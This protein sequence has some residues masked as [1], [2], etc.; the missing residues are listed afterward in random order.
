MSLLCF[1]FS[2][3]DIEDRNLLVGYINMYTENYNIAQEL[4]LKSSEPRTAL[5]VFEI[6]TMV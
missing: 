4:F 5:E 2:V 1:F 6:V 3:K